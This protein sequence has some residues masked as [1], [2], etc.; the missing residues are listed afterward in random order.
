MRTSVLFDDSGRL[1][2]STGTLTVGASLPV[3]ES[4]TI[5]DTLLGPW[6]IILFDVLAIIGVS[7]RSASRAWSRF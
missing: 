6:G 7:A 2:G 5:S 4:S 1:V 3:P